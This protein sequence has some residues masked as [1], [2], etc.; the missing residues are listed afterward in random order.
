MTSSQ[1]EVRGIVIER[2]QT[3][4]PEIVEALARLVP[5]LTN[6]KPPPRWSDLEAMVGTRTNVLFVARQGNAAG[7]IVGAGSVSS[8][9]VPTGV[10]AVIEDVVVD[11]TAR[12]QGIG[13]ALMNALLRA[14]R[15]MGAPGV[16][17]TSNPV[18]EAANRLY[19]RLGFQPRNTN[20]YYLSFSP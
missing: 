11:Q 3:V 6:N 8:Y 1:T 15:A 17:L 14:A 7:G 19:V 4:T 2:V 10:R 9:R 12:G 16:S 13:E 20:S 5:Q 18:R